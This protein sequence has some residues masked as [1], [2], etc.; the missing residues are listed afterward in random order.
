M[1]VCAIT[2][3]RKVRRQSRDSVD[4]RQRAVLFV[5]LEHRHRRVELADDVK[6]LAVRMKREVTRSGARL[7]LRKRLLP[8]RELSS[9][10]IEVVD[11]HFVHTEIR[12]ERV[13]LSAIEDDAMCVW[14][15]LLFFRS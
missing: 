9:R 11:H 2:G 15:F 8:R 7:Q 1:N 12:G 13:T 5:V 4:V 14:S 3:T 10:A 6:I